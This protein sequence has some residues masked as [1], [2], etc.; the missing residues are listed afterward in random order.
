[1]SGVCL[2]W[3]AT[4][5]FAQAKKATYSA[6]SILFI[7]TMGKGVEKQGKRIGI[8]EVVFLFIRGLTHQR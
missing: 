2:E 3:K 7:C 8:E 5:K 6:R 1:M 4:E